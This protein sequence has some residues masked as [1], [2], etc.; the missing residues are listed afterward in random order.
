MYADTRRQKG[1]IL[2]IWPGFV[3]ALA[4]LLIVMI[5]ALMIFVV[6]QFYLSDA[7]RGSQRGLESLQAKLQE[8][9]NL[10]R[11]EQQK[12]THI[13][14]SFNGASQRALDA[15]TLLASLQQQVEDLNR[16]LQTL[17]TALQTAETTTT[18]QKLTIEDLD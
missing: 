2:D 16:Q 1:V 5:F 11:I 15:E 13:T 14:K 12:N 8:I 4:T 6:S 10:L 7:L 3:D 18:Q 9:S 17:N